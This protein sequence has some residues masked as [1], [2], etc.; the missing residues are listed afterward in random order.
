MSSQHTEPYHDL[1]LRRARLALRA[2]P[3]L[4]L[5]ALQYR[6]CE[7]GPRR[8]DPI[9]LERTLCE[10]A[11]TPGALAE[12][13]PGMYS[14]PEQDRAV[15][16]AAAEEG[17]V[18]A[19]A[20][21]AIDTSATWR[22]LAD[23]IATLL[24]AST[25]H[26]RTPPHERLLVPG[27]HVMAYDGSLH[28]DAGLSTPVSLWL[29]WDAKWIY[30]HDSRLWQ[31]LD[32]CGRRRHQPVVLARKNAPITFPLFKA[33]GVLGLQYYWWVVPD[34]CAKRLAASADDAG[35]APVRDV[36]CVADAPISTHLARVV[37]EQGAAP[38][39]PARHSAISSAVEYGLNA[40]RTATMAT[41]ARWAEAVDIALP[42]PWLMSVR[43]GD[44]PRPH[45][46]AQPDT[47]SAAASAD[48]TPST[49]DERNDARGAATHDPGDVL[50]E[51]PG[52]GRRTQVTRVPFRI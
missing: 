32:E 9:H 1:V 17:I 29:S 49:A 35:W 51:R 43:R 45:G 46:T 13:M 41:L 20:L 19:K 12:Y 24:P 40:E 6:L 30:P 8:L 22:A 39:D 27:A 16:L 26:P 25:I 42:E 47:G 28:I 4:G 36:R 5:P 15:A 31:F 14:D 11:G 52:F 38:L 3:A 33:L 21:G 2:R 10:M 34:G 18:A 50:A 44:T 37:A 23:R 48:D 7:V